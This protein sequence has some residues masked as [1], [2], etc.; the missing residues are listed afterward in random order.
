LFYYLLVPAAATAAGKTAPAKIGM[1]AAKTTAAGAAAKAAETA[2][3]GNQ[4]NT[5]A[6]P[7]GTGGQIQN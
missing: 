2:K 4:K 5:N 6:K 3:T 7:D 1:T